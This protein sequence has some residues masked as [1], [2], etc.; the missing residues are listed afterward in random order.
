MRSATARILL[1]VNRR[2][3]AAEMDESNSFG[4]VVVV[5]RLRDAIRR[6]NP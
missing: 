5:G 4:E 1:P 6:L 2:R 3:S